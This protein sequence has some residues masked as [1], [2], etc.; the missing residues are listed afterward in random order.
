MSK[1]KLKQLQ[2]KTKNKISI[3]SAFYLTVCLKLFMTF[4]FDISKKK[5]PCVSSLNID[6][7]F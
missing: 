4:M 1:R 5:S 2:K 7:L 6:M 3:N